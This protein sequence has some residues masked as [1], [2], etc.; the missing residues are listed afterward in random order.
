MKKNIKTKDRNLGER[1]SSK[2]NHNAYVIKAGKKTLAIL[3]FP[4]DSVDIIFAQDSVMRDIKFATTG[5]RKRVVNVL[6]FEEPREFPHPERKGFMGE[7]YLNG[8]RY[9]KDREYMTFLLIHGILHLAGFRHNGRRDT[10]EMQR[11]EQ[12]LVLCVTKKEIYKNKRTRT[13]N[14]RIITR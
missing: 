6:A 12:M 10:I 8:E 3:G 4:T 5:I 1:G 14:A 13:C 7:V 9:S 2:I 11:M